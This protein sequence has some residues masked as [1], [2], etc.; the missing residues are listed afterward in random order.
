LDEGIIKR[1][2][3]FIPTLFLNKQGLLFQYLR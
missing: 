1:A 3:V 2:G